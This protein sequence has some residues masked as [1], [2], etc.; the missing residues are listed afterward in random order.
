MDE[1][2]QTRIVGPSEND[3]QGGVTE[4]LPPESLNR[5]SF[6]ALLGGLADDAAEL[7]RKHVE[8]ARAELEQK[9]RAAVGAVAM[10]VAAAVLTILALGAFTTALI[11]VLARVLPDWA[12]ALVV[13]GGLIALAAALGF[14]GKRQLG[15]AAPLV[16]EETVETLKEDVAWAKSQLKS[17]Q[18]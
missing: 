12:A 17:A 10:W 14:A 9:V 4:A 5:R 13:G 15:K 7:V 2:G 8:L 6:R 11:L 18:R 1:D 16:P 3:E